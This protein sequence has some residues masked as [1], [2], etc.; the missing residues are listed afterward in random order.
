MIT[1]CSQRGGAATQGRENGGG[2]FR[3]KNG[4]RR[5]LF[6]KSEKLRESGSGDE[7]TVRLAG[8]EGETPLRGKQK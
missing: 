4:G 7:A 6:K 5:I 1:G 8:F 3:Q 2:N